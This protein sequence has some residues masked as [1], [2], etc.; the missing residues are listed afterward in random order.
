[1]SEEKAFLTILRRQPNDLVSMR[2]YADW[3]EDHD[4]PDRAEF[5]RIQLEAIE[6]RQYQRG[7]LRRSRRLVALG[8]T[9]PH[10]WLVVVNRP[11]LV[12]TAWVGTGTSDGFCIYRYRPKG[13]LNYT[14]E[15]GTYQNGT[16]WQ[17]GN[18]VFMETNNHYADYQGTIASERITGHASNISGHDWTWDVSLTTDPKECD[19]GNPDTTVYPHT[20]RERRRRRRRMPR[21]E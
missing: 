5:L 6:M 12:K 4:A 9:F 16:W 19:P 10:A 2:V 8:R 21:P 20:A 18:Q 14:T 7:L 3:L 11:R 1:M 13:V 15:S 17:I